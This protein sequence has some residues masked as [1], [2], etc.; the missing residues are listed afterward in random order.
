MNTKSLISNTRSLAQD[1][2]SHIS[3]HHFSHHLSRPHVNL[4]LPVFALLNEFAVT[5][6][7]CG[8]VVK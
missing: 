2:L 1:G 5:G 4:S 6:L 8:C 3:S 7:P